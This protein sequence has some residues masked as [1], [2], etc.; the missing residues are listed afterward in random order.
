MRWMYGV[1]SCPQRRDTLLPQTLR[2]LDLAGFPRPY[3]FCDGTFENGR[4]IEVDGITCHTPKVGAFG[5]WYLGLLEMYI[6]DPKVDRYAM[7][8]D[9]IV[10]SRNVR[11]YLERVPFHPKT[12][13]NLYT[14]PVNQERIGK[15]N[16]GI[17]STG[18][19]TQPPMSQYSFAGWFL[20]NQN[21]QSACALV[22]DNAGVVSLL[23]STQMIRQPLDVN[24]GT[25][26]IDGT[27]CRWALKEGY[28]EYCHYPSMVQHV[29][30]ESTLRKP[31]QTIQSR[32]FLGEEFDM[33]GILKEP[34]T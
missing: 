16:H 19:V 5:N 9:D 24:Y 32:C 15:P 3:I 34:K 13:L 10:C 23:Q 14:A 4:S 2:S 31:P 7:F 21:G 6:R 20:S 12:Y 22:F 18:W 27:V 25:R 28:R 1:T 29:G 30:A 8:Q 17:I 26:C 33:L 11:E